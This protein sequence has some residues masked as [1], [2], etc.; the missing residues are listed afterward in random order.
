[1]PHD[2]HALPAASSSL[3][4]HPVVEVQAG[5]FEARCRELLEQV[6]AHEIEVVVT[7]RGA[8][9]ARVVPPGAA[10][11]SAFGFL[12]GTVLRQD[13]LVSPDAE[14]WGPLG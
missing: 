12:R 6:Q 8:A 3:D 9:V 4:A 1:M 2:P 11:P 7:D 14:E 5:A 13:D 10:Q